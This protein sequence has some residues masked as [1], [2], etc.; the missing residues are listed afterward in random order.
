MPTRSATPT[1]EP[2]SVPVADDEALTFGSPILPGTYR[3]KSLAVEPARI[4]TDDGPKDLLRWTFVIDVD[5]RGEEIDA[6]SSRN[7]GPRAK[8]YA[9][10]TALLGR[11]PGPGE[12][13]RLV[14]LG[15]RD[16]LVSVETDDNGY[17][18][19][20]GVMAPTRAA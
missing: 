15:G 10:A 3:G 6:L 9:W 8:S 2:A 7:T 14:D 17:P 11:V 13:V 18:K 4:E 1:P 16:C 20:G 12:R 19:I 5:G